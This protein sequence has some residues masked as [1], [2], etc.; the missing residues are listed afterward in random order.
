MSIKT[1]R[2]IIG[3]IVFLG[4]AIVLFTT[5]QASVS[6]WDPGEISAASYSLMVPHPPGGPFWLMIGRIFSMIPFAHN[7]G[8]RINTVSVLSGIFTIFLLYLIIIKVIENY[9]G[10]DYKNKFD[11]VITYISAATG[12]LA[13][14]FCDTFWFNAT[15]SNYFALSTFLLALIV[16]LMMLWNERS[17]EPGN[18]KY[19]A[20]MAYLIGLSLGVHLMSVLAIF[21]FVFVVIMKKYVTDDE[22]Y[23]KTSYIFLIH[24][25]ILGLIAIGLWATQTSTTPPTPEQYQAFDR[26]FIYIMLGVSAIFMAAFRKKIFNRNSIY[27]PILIAAVALGIIYPGIVKIFPAFLLA[28]GG[29]G[30]I[31]NMVIVLIILGGLVYLIYWTAKNKRNILHLTAICFLFALIGFTTYAMIIIRSDQNPPMNE[32]SPDNFKKLMYYLDREQYG[33]FPIFMRRFSQEPNQQDIYKNYSS[34][35]DFFWRYQV[36]HMFNR[37]FLWNVVGKISTVQ[38]AGIKFSQLYAIPF[39]IGLFGFYFHFRKDWKMASAWLILFI[40]MGYLIAFYQNQQQPQPRD[41]FYFYPGSLMV[42]AV[43]IAIGIRELAEL[44]R[45]KIKN[46]SLKKTI[47]VAFL[48]AG[49]LLVPGNMLRTNYASHDRF[50]NWLPWDFSY[51]L[52][53][54]VKPNAILFTNGDND[55]F[56]LWYLQDVEGV[57]RDVRI[58]CLSLANTSWYVK[59]LKDLSPYGAE[60]IKFKMSNQAIENLQPVRWKSQEESVPVSEKAIKEFGVTDSS[61]IKHHMLTWRMNNT[62][63]FGGVKAVR[64]QDLVVKDIIQS[65]A[66]SRPIYFASTTSRDA[67]IGLGKYLEMEGLASRLVPRKAPG[68]EYVNTKITDEDLFDLNPSFS[69]SYKPGFKFR[70]LRNK[71][72]Y[73]T[74]TESR[75]IQNYRNTF[76]RLA[77]YYRVVAHNDSMSIYTLN[78]MESEIPRNVVPLDYRFLYDIANLYRSNGDVKKFNELANEIVPIATAKLNAPNLNL[79]SPYNPYSMLERLYVELKQYDKAIGVMQKLQNLYPGAQSIQQEIN[80]LKQ[81]QKVNSIINKQK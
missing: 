65:N 9:R 54:S 61:V 56:P 78:K 57:R 80:R 42:F 3:A 44:A 67:F 41:R 75:L 5:V 51:N 32:N 55:T 20:L 17:N 70:G 34:D 48:G 40:F 63:N 21:T 76:V 60:K 27:I 59:Q 10:K 14:A 33:N 71:N 50:N 26:K 53:Q 22:K 62:V 12:A 16:W 45:D 52:L 31:T 47:V 28:I 11:A 49:L 36:N 18:E 38:G 66:W 30:V 74:D 2:R 64:I 7:I 25:A 39:L 68:P 69:K 46:S 6:F 81:M 1:I 15:E 79:R 58:V 37:Y 72:V 4:T 19:I 8:F 73:F 13:F 24:L 23:L 77:Y 35:L 29:P 43:W